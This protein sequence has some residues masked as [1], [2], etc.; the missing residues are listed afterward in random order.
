[1]TDQHRLKQLVLHKEAIPQMF[2]EGQLVTKGLPEGSQVVNFAYD[3]A[4]ATYRITIQ[5]DAFE[6][7]EKG[8]EIPEL[9]L[10]VLDTALRNTEK[11]GLSDTDTLY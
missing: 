9:E 5:N 7:V 6:K 11:K 3:E 10:E 8:D 1:M 2:R 4:T